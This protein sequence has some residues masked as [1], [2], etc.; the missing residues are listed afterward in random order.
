MHRNR[1]SSS[2]HESDFFIN[3]QVETE[4]QRFLIMWWLIIAFS[5]LEDSVC[6]FHQIIVVIL[7]ISKLWATVTIKNP[8]CRINEDT[9]MWNS[10][11]LSHPWGILMLISHVWILYLKLKIPDFSLL[12]H[13]RLWMISS[14][15][16][17][18]LCLGFL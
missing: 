11:M 8:T 15:L 6:S 14:P 18:M 13:A 16:T 2:F 17:L 4:L 1:K 12:F 9:E 3:Q 5:C 10:K 7:N